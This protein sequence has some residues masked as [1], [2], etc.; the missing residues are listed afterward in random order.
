MSTPSNTPAVDAVKVAF[1]RWCLDEGRLSPSKYDDGIYDHRDTRWAW[2]GWKAALAAQA[3]GAVKVRELVW[4]KAALTSRFGDRLAI[5]LAD[6]FF[7]TYAVEKENDAV[8]VLTLAGLTVGERQGYST[9]EA[10]QAAA[11]AHF[12]ESILSALSAAP[13]VEREE[14]PIPLYKRVE[15][16]LDEHSAWIARPN[17]E[18]TKRVALAAMFAAH[19]VMTEE[20]ELEVID[21]EATIKLMVS[22]F[23]RWTLPDDFNPDGGIS[24][25]RHPGHVPV[26]TN[27]LT[28]VQAAD[29]VRYILDG[30]PSVAIP[31]LTATPAPSQQ[32]AGEAGGLV[33]ALSTMRLTHEALMAI[34]DALDRIVLEAG[35][36][37]QP[38]P[39]FVAD[40][41]RHGRE[42][43]DRLNAPGRIRF[44]KAYD[45]L[46]ADAARIA[47]LEAENAAKDARVAELEERA[48]HWRDVAEKEYLP[49]AVAAETTGAQL[50]NI[51]EGC[52]TTARDLS[53]KAARDDL[54]ISDL[55]AMVLRYLAR[56][57][58]AEALATKAEAD[59]V[60]LT[61]AL[62]GFGSDFMTS[63]KHHPGYVLIPTDQ[64][65]RVRAALGRG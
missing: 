55:N 49:R 27:L 48:E 5:R 3:P 30:F 26:G 32:P 65:E 21:V 62:D 37:S 41:I 11:Y 10:A 33:E 17:D 18:V 60:R 4:V 34:T 24:F 20:E 45:S 15:A 14:V 53:A 43:I 23:L 59:V 28:A 29:M 25:T 22:R 39:T 40:A 12:A 38:I 47:E 2:R 46:E 56:A 64:F 61:E 42:T 19:S 16:I 50:S 52:R 57:E 63:E 9:P 54:K 6:T 58:A 7:G 31:A 1:E 13:P 35:N 36:S 44:E 51:L 8:F